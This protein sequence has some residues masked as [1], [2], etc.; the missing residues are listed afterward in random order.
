MLVNYCIMTSFIINNTSL[1]IHPRKYMV[2]YMRH[3][4]LV[5]VKYP[6]PKENDMSKW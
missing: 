2:L 5:L 1:G 4:M 3:N 6:K